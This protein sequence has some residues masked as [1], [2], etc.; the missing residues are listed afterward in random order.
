M[1]DT[2][3]MTESEIEETLQ[4]ELLRSRDVSDI[5]LAFWNYTQRMSELVQEV[6][7]ASRTGHA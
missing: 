2:P 5:D 1:Q 4:L 7:F 3:R 6:P